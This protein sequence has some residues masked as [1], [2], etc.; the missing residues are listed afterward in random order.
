MT[1]TLPLLPPAPEGE[2]REA[3]SPVRWSRV[4]RAI[5]RRH[6]LEGEFEPYA[7]GSD[8]GCRVGDA[9]GKLTTPQWVGELGVQ[10]ALQDHLS[11]RLPF[12]VPE[13]LAEGELE[14][15]PYLIMQRLTAPSLAQVWPQLG[16]RERLRLAAR[17]GA[18]TAAL[19]AVPPP[20]L[21]G[22]SWAS[23][24]RGLREGLAS[25]YRERGLDPTWAA[26][27]EPFVRAVEPFPA[28][29]LVLLHTELLGEHVLVEDGPR[30][31]DVAGLIDLADGRAGSAEYDFVA[32]VEFVFRG[33]P[34]C[35]R[36]FLQGYG[37]P[38]EALGLHTQRRLL[39][40]G[41]LHR[42]GSVG[43]MLAVAGQP[44]PSSLEQVARRVYAL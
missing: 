21:P 1:P 9:G 37:Y 26:Q 16:G 32:P 11:G 34:G 29:G 41:L 23:F 18:A 25:R 22:P 3:V 10:R 42:Y 6:G 19:H 27:L 15:W 14:G 35:L 5:A 28:C 8:V 17:L 24:R 40:W 4:A 7:S 39:A 30:G 44:A 13:V 38:A 20:A 33:Q 2:L 43:R 36:A 12:A 31:W